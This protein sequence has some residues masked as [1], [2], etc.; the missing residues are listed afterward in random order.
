MCVI[1]FTAIGLYS[2]NGFPYVLTADL[3][4]N[5]VLR[6]WRAVIVFVF[7]KF[8]L[9]YTIDFIDLKLVKDS[10]YSNT[11]IMYRIQYSLNLPLVKY[12]IVLKSSHK[13]KIW[14]LLCSYGNCYRCFYY[15]HILFIHFLNFQS[16]PYAFV[17]YS[18]LALDI[19]LCFSWFFSM[20]NS[21]VCIWSIV[22]KPKKNYL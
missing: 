5:R 3:T 7:S 6:S 19:C 10:I 1:W 11:Y 2:R 14:T 22:E 17:R 20:R 8:N 18:F 4:C 15:F 21:N 9:R 12:P 13:S 16:F